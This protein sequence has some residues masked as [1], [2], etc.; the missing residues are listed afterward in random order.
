MSASAPI[1]PI[2]SAT[3]SEFVAQEMPGT[4]AAMS[5]AGEYADIIYEVIFF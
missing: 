1:T 4:G 3:G 5:A 2:R